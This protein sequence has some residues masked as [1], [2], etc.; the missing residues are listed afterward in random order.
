[1]AP[2]PVFVLCPDSFKGTFSSTQ[3]AR[4]L[5]KAAQARFPGCVCRVLPVAD[6]GEG[7]VDA[8]VDAL[9]GRKVTVEVAGPL[10][11]RKSVV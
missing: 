3:V 11:D 7:T 1:M 8:L 9:A 10:G 5:K 6:G 2:P 4:E